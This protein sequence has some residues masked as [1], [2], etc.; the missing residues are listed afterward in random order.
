MKYQQV[1]AKR[2]GLNRALETAN[3]E[4]IQR[5]AREIR[6]ENRRRVAVWLG[7]GNRGRLLS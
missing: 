3:D 6:A 2:I 4:A 5:L 7:T 1:E